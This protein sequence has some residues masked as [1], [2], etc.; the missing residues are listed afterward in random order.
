MRAA[1]D[2]AWSALRRIGPCEIARDESKARHVGSACIPDVTRCARD[3]RREHVAPLDPMFIT[4]SF[5]HA[6]IYAAMVL[7]NRALRF[8]VLR[9]LKRERFSYVAPH[10]RFLRLLP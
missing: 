8:H 6:M 9:F 5:I 2:A 4:L 1:A 7:F 10:S 3:G